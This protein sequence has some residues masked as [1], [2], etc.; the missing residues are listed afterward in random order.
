MGKTTF[1]NNGE[2]QIE[3]S[4]GKMQPIIISDEDK[5]EKNPKQSLLA[6]CAF[7]SHFVMSYHVRYADHAGIASGR[8]ALTY[9][10]W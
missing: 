7:I 2:P 10:D 1:F 4:D 3:R 5:V 8:R 6:D 9:V